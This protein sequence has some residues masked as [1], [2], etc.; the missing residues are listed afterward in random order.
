MTEVARLRVVSLAERQTET[1]I[2]RRRA[3]ADSAPA[4]RFGY[5][6]LLRAALAGWLAGD[7]VVDR[8]VDCADG[9]AS[10]S[11]FDDVDLGWPR[12]GVVPGAEA[13]V[14][15]LVVRRSGGR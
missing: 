6:P 13:A 11:C 15:S 3:S 4:Q 9:H 5:W 8:P 14:I 7:E 10:E 1:R 2:P 12:R